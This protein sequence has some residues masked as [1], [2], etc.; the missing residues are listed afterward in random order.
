MNLGILFST[1]CVHD[2]TF[3]LCLGKVVPS[4]V[5]E[6]NLFISIRSFRK[7][8]LTMGYIG[9]IMYNS[10]TQAHNCSHG[11]LCSCHVL[12]Y[13]HIS[14]AAMVSRWHWILLILLWP[15]NLTNSLWKGTWS[16]LMPPLLMV[17]L[18]K[19]QHLYRG[20]CA[21]LPPNVIICFLSLSG[22]QSPFL[23]L[24]LPLN[25]R[26]YPWDHIESSR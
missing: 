12:H 6:F 1:L 7:P 22:G 13:S 25:I 14:L 26:I 15:P 10:L 23:S 4:C 8:L 9:I 18:W 2:Y 16:C 24:L 21:L 5:T 11:A 20:F 19:Y 17:D 3:L